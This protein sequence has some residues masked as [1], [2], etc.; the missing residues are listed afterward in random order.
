MSSKDRKKQ[1]RNKRM[2][3]GVMVICLVG[4]LIA[5]IFMIQGFVLNRGITGS[6]FLYGILIFV[7]FFLA[8]NFISPLWIEWLDKKKGNKVARGKQIP[9]E[10]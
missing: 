7:L 4:V 5:M 8:G 9:H 1:K 2:R 10:L 6:T 3:I